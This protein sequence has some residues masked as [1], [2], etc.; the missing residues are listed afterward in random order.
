MPHITV[1]CYANK[2]KIRVPHKLSNINLQQ[3]LDACALLH[4]TRT[5]IYFWKPSSS[6]MKINLL[7]IITLST[8]SPKPQPMMKANQKCSFFLWNITEHFT[9]QENQIIKKSKI[10]ISRLNISAP[11]VTSW[12]SKVPHI[13]ALLQK[14]PE[15]FLG[16]FCSPELPPLKYDH[17]RFLEFP[18]NKK[19]FS[20]IHAIKIYFDHYFFLSNT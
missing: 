8:Q 19:R 20:D 2:I 15:C 10:W 16:S 11:Y 18:F 12:Q 1:P 9:F 7:V 17:F 6:G 14:L 3:R 13:S 5:T 4:E